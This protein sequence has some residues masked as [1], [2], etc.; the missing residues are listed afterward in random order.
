M[1]H[2]PGR[3]APVP[4]LLRG[5]TLIELLLAITV[6]VGL[7]AVVGGFLDSA[8]R[9]QT[10]WGDATRPY[11]QMAQAF[12]RLERDLE[13]AQ[14]FFGIRFTGTEASLELAR[15][16]TVSMTDAGPSTEWVR[17]SYRVEAEAGGSV[18]VR[19]ASVWRLGEEGAVSRT[20]ERLL[21]LAN[22]RFAFGALDPQG[23]QVWVKA[24]SDPARTVARLIKFDCTVPT[25]AGR[26]PIAFSRI[27][28]NPAGALPA[29]EGS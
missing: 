2:R 14:P 9:L 17:V 12:N 3:A 19:E 10:K 13:A 6:F 11:Q 27:I 16:E 24:W 29:A 8:L 18:L 1:P 28:R 23:Q 25:G 4:G 7:M 26:A 20:R 15:V 5:L 21:S 22:G